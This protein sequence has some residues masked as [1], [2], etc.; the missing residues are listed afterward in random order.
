MN[1][2][3]VENFELLYRVVRKSDPDGF[4]DNKPTAALFLDPVGTSVDRDGGRTEEQIIDTFKRRFNGKNRKDYK[5][6]VKISA[7][8]CRKSGAEPIPNPG[9]NKYHAL[10]QETDKIVALSL[11]TAMKIAKCCTV[12]NG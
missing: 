2:D 3:R 12:I 9:N 10:L 4:I 7:E 5:A 1:L 11:L 8:L 6:A